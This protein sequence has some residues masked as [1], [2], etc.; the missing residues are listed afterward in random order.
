MSFAEWRQRSKVF[1]VFAGRAESYGIARA[2]ERVCRAAYKA[3][4]REGMRRAEAAT[5][6]KGDKA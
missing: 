3:G 6:A 5:L 2:F 1:A 4:V